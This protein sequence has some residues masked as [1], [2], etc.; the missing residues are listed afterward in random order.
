MSYISSG[1]IS[2][3]SGSVSQTAVSEIATFQNNIRS[4][5]QGYETFLQGSY[6]NDTAISDINDVD[7]IALE[8]PL[9][10]FLP[11][12]STSSNLFYN[13]KSKLETNQNY[14]GRI[15][16]GRKCLTLTL[17]T[18]KA[19]I[20]PA[21]RVGIGQTNRFGEP[22]MIGQRILNFPR[23]HINNSQVKNQHTSN[24]YKRI[25][26]M[27]KN[28]VNNWNLKSIAPSFYIECVIY[29][30][31]DNWFSS[32]LS[33]SL[34]SILS[35]MIGANFNPNFTTVAGDKIVISQTEWNPQSFIAF[36]NHVVSQLPY[37]STALTMR[38]E[39]H[40]NANFRRFFNS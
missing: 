6:A 40:A 11:S 33:N 5:L 31:P 24:N 21:T 35:Y 25:V 30:Y 2:Q 20:V 15:T 39:T 28:Y 23:T 1:L 29:S 32:D 7:I 13:I 37:L 12:L 3:V 17:A 27:L 38:D 36:K 34:N 9:L 18:R 19:D 8:R 22:I 10:W 26:R 16:V 14:R 4:L